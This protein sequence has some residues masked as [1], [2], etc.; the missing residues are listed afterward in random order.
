MKIWDLILYIICN[1]E[2]R[3]SKEILNRRI[4]R[5]DL[6]RCEPL[7]IKYIMKQQSLNQN[8]VSAKADKWKRM[9]DPEKGP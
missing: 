1:K 2:V 9:Q 4:S 3:L 6:L 8:S 5:E 7:N